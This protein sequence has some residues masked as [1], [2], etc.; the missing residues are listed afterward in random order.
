[1]EKAFTAEF[2]PEISDEPGLAV[3]R[4]E[5][6]EVFNT[7]NIN[8]FRGFFGHVAFFIKSSCSIGCRGEL[9]I[10]TK[11][12]AFFWVE[13]SFFKQLIIYLRDKITKTKR[14]T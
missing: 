4:V 2:L 10:V 7:D 1:M 9:M 6:L 12:I 8:V 5:P 11:S 14:H 13:S 3:L